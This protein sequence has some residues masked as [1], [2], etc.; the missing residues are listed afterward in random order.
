ARRK[1]TALSGPISACSSCPPL[2]APSR[3][4]PHAPKPV[5]WV[6]KTHLSQ[7]S[8]CRPRITSPEAT[9]HREHSTSPQA[10]KPAWPMVVRCQFSLTQPRLSPWTSRWIMLKPSVSV[11]SMCTQKLP[12]FVGHVLIKRKT[13][14]LWRRRWIPHQPWRSSTT[15]CARCTK[16]WFALARPAGWCIA[17]ASPTAHAA[18]RHPWH[19]ADRGRDDRQR[20]HIAREYP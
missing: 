11:D 19:S 14:G 20:V 16:Q 8:A 17:A 3:S 9:K 2:L 5:P 15:R 10:G 7:G 4:S 18:W 6:L 12:F 13:T 1:N